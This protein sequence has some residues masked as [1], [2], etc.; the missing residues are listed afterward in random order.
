VSKS[1]ALPPLLLL[2]AL[3][4]EPGADGLAYAAAGANPAG[5]AAIPASAE[6]LACYDAAACGGITA[7]EERL[8]C[9]DALAGRKSPGPRPATVPATPAQ[10]ASDDADSFGLVKPQPPAPGPDKIEARV[11]GLTADRQ[12]HVTVTLDNGQTWA[13]SDAD[14][15]LQSGDTVT[16]RHAAL[17]SYLLTTTARH[18]YRVQ[19]LK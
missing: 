19:R 10:P 18:S 1:A 7:T 12:G 2:R 17:G 4:A 5:C 6:R 11:V 13:V 16:I 8:G 14:S 9:Y 15:R 3:L